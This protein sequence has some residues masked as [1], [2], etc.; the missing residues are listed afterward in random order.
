[1]LGMKRFA[2]I[3]LLVCLATFSFAQEKRGPSTPEERAKVVQIA[4][5]LEND[6]VAATMRPEREWLVRFLID[7]PDINL[8][9]CG[10]SFPY[11]KK[12]KFGPDLLAVSMAGMASSIIEH[13]ETAKDSAVVGQAGL[14]AVLR[15]YTKLLETHPKDHSKKLDE[16]LVHQKDGTL[17]ELFKKEWNDSCKNQG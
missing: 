11:E 14:E 10:A 3:L 2:T 12:F 8:K 6:P 15:A 1:M 17:P 4:K 9:L 13:P 16:S 5:A 7:V